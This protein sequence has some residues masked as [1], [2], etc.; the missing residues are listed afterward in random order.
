MKE[1]QYR[2]KKCG[3]TKLIPL[4]NKEG[5]VIPHAWLFCECYEEPPENYH[6]LSPSDFDFPI[7]YSYYRSLCHYHGWPD[8]G[9][10]I[11]PA[12]I[13]EREIRPAFRPRPIDKEIDQ[14]KSQFLYVQNKFNEILDQ[15]RK[16]KKDKLSEGI[17]IEQS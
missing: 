5:K 1:N 15:P 16:R 8:P 10:D 7:S 6:P 9:P 11:A 17:D 3:G 12:T 2:C 14:L 4:K 13:A